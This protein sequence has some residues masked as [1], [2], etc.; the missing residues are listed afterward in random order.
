MALTVPYAA[1]R[2]TLELVKEAI[3]GKILVDVVVPLT[4]PQIHKAQMPPAGSAAQ[5]AREILGPDAEIADAFQ[6]ISFEL[7]MSADVVECDVLVTGTGKQVRAEVIKLVEAAGLIGWD[8]GPLEN[9]AVVEGM[10][11]VLIYMNRHYESTHAGIRV[12]GIARS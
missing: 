2:E 3:K 8:A 5:E 1:H 4:P 7:L 9:S 11:S 10:S 12:T 6:N